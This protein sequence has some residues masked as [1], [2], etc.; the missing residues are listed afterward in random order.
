VLLEEE[1]VTVPVGVLPFTDAVQVVATL[2]PTDEGEQKTVT[3]ETTLLRTNEPELG[4]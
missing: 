2:A 1:K 4:S 3:G